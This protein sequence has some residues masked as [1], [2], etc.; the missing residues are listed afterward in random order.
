MVG[1]NLYL[2]C[3]DDED[4]VNNIIEVCSAIRLQFKSVKKCE[5]V[6]LQGERRRRRRTNVEELL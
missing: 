4:G 6:Y 2:Q 5:T 1:C 3:F